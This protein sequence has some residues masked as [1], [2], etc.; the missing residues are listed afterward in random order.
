MSGC[1][2]WIVAAQIILILAKALGLLL[3][4]WWC[5]LAPLEVF[6]LTLMQEIIKE[7]IR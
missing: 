7:E 3:W 5:V 1:L 6:V 2:P 4:P